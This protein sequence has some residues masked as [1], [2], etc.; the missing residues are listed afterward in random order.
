LID[1]IASADDQSLT[2][3]HTSV[4]LSMSSYLQRAYRASDVNDRYQDLWFF[5]DVSVN[6]DPRA[7][8][9]FSRIALDAV[10]RM[11]DL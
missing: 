5:N 7:W 3:R 4:E 10:A 11:V 2:A 8:T 1:H 6:V 9:A